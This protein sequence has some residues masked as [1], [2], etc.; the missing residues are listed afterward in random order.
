VIKVK[1]H[2][3]YLGKT[4]FAAHARGFF[5]ELSKHVE[6][7][8]RNF[9]WDDDPHYL[10]DVDKSV[11]EEISLYDSAGVFSDYPISH[12]FPQIN[13]SAQG[14]FVQDV[15]IVLMNVQHH[16][17]TED[18]KAPVKIAYTV[19]ESTELPDHAF[20]NLLHK[21]D[22]LWVPTEW[23]RD[24]AVKQ[25]YPLHR[26][27]VVNE[28]VDEEFCND[29]VKS[30]PD[31]YA[32]G[33]FKFLFFGRWDY[34]KAVP[35]IVDT[36]LKTFGKDEPVDLVLS[37]DNP[38]AMDGL[39]STEERLAKHG[40]N[41]SRI[42]IKHFVSRSDYVSY[43]KTGNALVSCAR[44]EGWNIPLIEAMAAGTP[45]IYTEWGAQLEFAKS[46]GLPVKITGEMPAEIGAS[47]GMAESCPG[48]YAEGDY[49]D[50]SRVMRDCYENYTERKEK[51]LIERE[52]IRKRFNWETIGK[53]SSQYL[54]SITSAGFPEKNGEAA[55]VMTH[56][57][58]D[59]KKEMLK[60]CF[61]TLMHQGYTV[62]VSSHIPVP[63]V[64]TKNADYLIIDKDNPVIYPEEHNQYSSGI[65]VYWMKAGDFELVY[66]FDY[67]HGYAALKLI[68]NGCA[69]A[70][71]NR[72]EIV[73]YVNY[74]YV[75]YDPAVL[76]KHSCSL[77]ENDLVT[78][79][80]DPEKSVN[81]GLF[82]AKSS[83]YLSCVEQVNSK[84]DYLSFYNTVTLEDLM[85]KL[86]EQ[87]SLKMDVYDDIKS[88]HENN[89]VNSINCPGTTIHI[90]NRSG[91][92]SH[93]YFGS[94]TDGNDYIATQGTF[95]EPLNFVIQVKDDSFEY[96]AGGWPMK[97]IKIPKT[98]VTHGFE[99]IA[100]DYGYHRK[101]DNRSKRGNFVIH[102]PAIVE[103][104][105]L[106]GGIDELVVP[107]VNYN[108]NFVDGPFAEVTSKNSDDK[109]LVSFIDMDEMKTMYQTVIGTN[110]WAKCNR[111]YYTNWRIEFKNLRTGETYE[112]EMNLKGQRV[113]FSIDSSSLGDNLAWFPHIAQFIE[114]KGCIGVVSTFKNEFYRDTYPHIQFV[115][116][117]QV[118]NGLHAAYHIGWFYDENNGPKYDHHPR[119]FR[120]L[121]MQ[122]TTTD[123]LGMQHTPLKPVIS[124]PDGDSA[125]TEPYVCL[126]FHATAQAKYWNNPAGWQELTD[127]LL[128]SG[129]KVVVLSNEND[130]HMGN[131]YPKGVTV[132]PPGRSLRDT[133]TY[134]KGAT[135]FIGIG[136]GLSWLAWAMNVPSVLISGFSWPGTEAVDQNSV[137]VFNPDVCN[138]CFNRAR[139]DAG[140]WNWCPDHKG[141]HRQFECTRNISGKQVIE[142]C[143]QILNAV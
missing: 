118:V 71:A 79:W 138:G 90:D 59:K 137:R 143:N 101:F 51:A 13:W 74:D 45:A 5:R 86:Y 33:R 67:N 16:S 121:P 8:V 116:P 103:D 4:G 42:R 132:L 10:N 7:R 35:E 22:Y 43:I 23:H 123:I 76:Q 97:F 89:L 49:E 48:N 139:L 82:S 52:D 53:K 34:R 70:A 92:V 81:T 127:H 91:G 63:D 98:V 58:E 88:L 117:G 107:A 68:K 38:F 125:I 57:D 131:S 102:N 47:L 40:F 61:N 77:Q 133:M 129:Y 18:Y 130:G 55:V 96:V 112:H 108:V 73:H 20:R 21:F 19:W 39:K 136:S 93:I 17:F 30:L 128:S 6:L 14:E 106:I 37:A 9:T 44:S 104:L 36:F 69:L 72:Y 142:A 95:E 60:R 50:L 41:D 56:A 87:H 62:I 80:W 46:K 31:E 105:P 64:V 83:A 140:D 78:Y 122:A 25:G 100:S 3:C 120:P 124:I 15:D 65:P 28:G 27:F 135:A 109:Y 32:D 94:D 2:T 75:L 126:G 54:K 119:D 111:K 26:I 134:L 29:E 110:C 114:D 141:T 99:V 66:P 12:S 115:E 85:T 113:F 1:A 84:G 24:M 11:L